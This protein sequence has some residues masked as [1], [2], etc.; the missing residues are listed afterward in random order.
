MRI[1]KESASHFRAR[2]ALRRMLIAATAR[3]HSWLLREDRSR[4]PAEAF[5]P[6]E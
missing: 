5:S 6:A 1:N 4:E 3:F 2:S